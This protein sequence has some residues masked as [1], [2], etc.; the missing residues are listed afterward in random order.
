MKI[1]PVVRL[2]REQFDCFRGVSAEALQH[3]LPVFRLFE[4]RETETLS[5]IA[6]TAQDQLLVVLGRVRIGSDLWDPGRSAAAPLVLPAPPAQTRIEAIDDSVLCHLDLD[7]LDIL[8]TEEQL[9]EAHLDARTR[10]HLALVQGT[11]LIRKLPL[12]NVDEALGLLREETLVPGEEPVKM[13]REIDRFAILVEGG[14]E[15]WDIDDEEGIPRKA[16][17]LEPGACFGEEGL[18]MKAPSP[19]TVRI[20]EPSLV[21]TLGREDFQRLLARPLLREV[22]AQ[23]AKTMTDQGH[24]LLD[25]RLEEEY[26]EIHIPGATLI[27]LSQLRARAQ[28]LDSDREYVVYCR[29]G[30]RSAV[31]TFLLG[32]MGRRAVN[33][34]G[35]ILAWPF[36]VEGEEV[37][38]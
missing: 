11:A 14:A 33:L 38:S 6:S 4:L 36:A 30:R 17:D 2:L 1:E 9:L 26:E 15:L 5:L 32:Q 24:P 18:L 25:V 34:L 22:H 12:E 13:G 20:T 21:R 29:S 31:A 37:G 8:L 27:P 35:G 28:E 16:R 23:V 10:R 7:L 19:V 3:S